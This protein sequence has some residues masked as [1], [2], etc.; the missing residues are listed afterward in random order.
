MFYTERATCKRCERRRDCYVVGRRAGGSYNRANR[1]YRSRICAECA[2][3][4]LAY[5][6]P[7]P[8]NLTVSGWNVSGLRALVSH[9]Y[10][11]QKEKQ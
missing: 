1:L 11:P 3:S 5:I 4:L 9:L 10:T 7:Y 6:L 8:S 2:L